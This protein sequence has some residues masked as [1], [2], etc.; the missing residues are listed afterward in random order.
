MENKTLLELLNAAK[1]LPDHRIDR[2]LS[3]AQTHLII[4]QKFER[5]KKQ[6]KGP[7][8]DYLLICMP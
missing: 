6:G 2:L 3:Q 8:L 5:I 4:H 1:K 7:A